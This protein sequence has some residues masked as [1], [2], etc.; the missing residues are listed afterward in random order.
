MYSVLPSTIKPYGIPMHKKDKSGGSLV[1]VVL[2]LCS[3]GTI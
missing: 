2:K 1:K 3:L